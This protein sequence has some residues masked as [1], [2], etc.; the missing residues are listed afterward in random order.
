VLLS[1]M[2]VM[3]TY[4]RDAVRLPYWLGELAAPSGADDLI[5][6]I[7]N[8]FVIFTF[9]MVVGFGLTLSRIHWKKHAYL[10]VRV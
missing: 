6:I 4:L 3:T 8:Y 5:N 7:I 9:S 2:F 1:F 10:T